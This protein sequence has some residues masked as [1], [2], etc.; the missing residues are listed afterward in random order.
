MLIIIC[1]NNG[2]HV[3]SNSNKSIL[4]TA[5][6]IKTKIRKHNLKLSK[7]ISLSPK[8]FEIGDFYSN[9]RYSYP[10]SPNFRLFLSD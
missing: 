7:I 2:L 1:A 5:I 3:I 8:N 9:G 4:P 10:L 6:P